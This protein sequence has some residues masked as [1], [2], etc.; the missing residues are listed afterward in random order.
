MSKLRREGLNKLQCPIKV[1]PSIMPLSGYT[2]ITEER[3]QKL[4]KEMAVKTKR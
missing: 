1:I 3:L 2:Q 4:I